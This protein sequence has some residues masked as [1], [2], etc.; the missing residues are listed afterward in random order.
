MLVAV[1]LVAIDNSNAEKVEINALQDRA[2]PLPKK[3]CS[4]QGIRERLD[5]I[6][7]VRKETTVKPEQKERLL[8]V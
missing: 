4:Q 3:D 8:C 5:A 1:T 7:N 2:K 6:D